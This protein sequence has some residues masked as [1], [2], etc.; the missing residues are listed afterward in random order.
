MSNRDDDFNF[1]DIGQPKP[2]KTRK[3]QL[4]SMMTFLK[5]NNKNRNFQVLILGWLWQVKLQGQ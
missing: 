5:M 4:L 2:K 3:T 1:E